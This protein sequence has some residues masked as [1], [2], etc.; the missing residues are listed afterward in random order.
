MKTKTLFA[1]LT[2]LFIFSS[3]SFA[4]KSSSKNAPRKKN[5]EQEI[6]INF[7]DNCPRTTAALGEEVAL[8]ATIPGYKG[9][10]TVSYLIWPE[11]KHAYPVTGFYDCCEK[12]RSAM[13]KSSGKKYI[14]AFNTK[15]DL[16]GLDLDLSS[17]LKSTEA[18][19]RLLESN[20]TEVYAFYMTE[21]E[22]DGYLASKAAPRT[23][24]DTQ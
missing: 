3:E 16:S 5:L 17:A 4:K 8:R 14:L 11:E 20:E 9:T 18:A 13:E 12:I 19:T 2:V 1:V 23:E 15:M 6:T 22:Y 21:A 10:I 7:H 24:Q